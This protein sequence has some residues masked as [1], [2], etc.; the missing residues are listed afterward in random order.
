MC[1]VSTYIQ[2]QSAVTVS[3]SDDMDKTQQLFQDGN[4]TGRGNKRIVFCHLI[5]VGKN[6]HL[7]KFIM[8]WLTMYGGSVMAVQ[9]GRLNV[10]DEQSSGQPSTSAD[11]VQDIEAAVQADRCVSTAQLELRFNLSQGIMWDNVH[12]CLGYRK[13]S[14]KW[15][16]RNLTDEHERH[17]WGHPSYFFNVLNSMVKH[18]YAALLQ[19]MRLGSLTTLQ[20]ARL[21]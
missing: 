8:S 13:V 9:H 2:H 20:R 19:K 11:P 5:F 12:E 17:T 10:K 15:V 16:P 21:H 7:L 18:S 1:S 14:S 6:F 3:T 4:H